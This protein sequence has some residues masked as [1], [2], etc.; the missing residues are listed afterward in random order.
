MI[1]VFIGTKAQLIKMAPILRELDRR[2]IP[3]N[4][5]DTGQH[6]EITGKL[7]KQFDLRS[8]DVTLRSEQES[9]KTIFQAARWMISS[10][11]RIVFRKRVICEEW[12]LGESG[13]CL[14]HGDTLSTLLSLI[15]AKRC[16]IEVAHVEAGLR[17]FHILDPFPEEI[18]R[19]IV[20]R[21]SDILFAPSD[22][23]ES[24]LTTMGYQQKTVHIGGNTIV[25]ALDYAVEHMETGSVPAE[26]FVVVTIHRVET[27]YSKK[28]LAKIERLLEKISKSRKVLFILHPPT[29]DQLDQ[30]DLL[31]SLKTNPKIELLPLQSYFRFVSLLKEADLVVTDG[32]SIQEE[33]SALDVPCLIMRTRTERDEG[34]GDN[35]YLSRFDSQRIEWFL[36]SWKT[37][38]KSPQDQRI[39]PSKELV[40]HLLASDRSLS[41]AYTETT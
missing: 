27:I 15:Y 36:N 11:W 12:F 29:R 33:T 37:L 34:L 21:Y 31:D 24:N 20:M 14:I 22:W 23:A 30:F 10:L 9:I 6:A 32:G 40:D 41:S 13:I 7:R 17:S 8:P 26:P 18:I 2:N 5:L 3:Y 39:S 4:L 38:K 1:H 19:L 16:G 25:D 28:R 35:A